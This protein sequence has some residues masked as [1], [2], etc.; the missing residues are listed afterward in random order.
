MAATP[1]VIQGLRSSPADADPQAIAWQADANG[2]R[3]LMVLAL[4][5]KADGSFGYAQMS[6][7]GAMS[8][9]L[10]A[11]PELWVTAPGGQALANGDVQ[12]FAPVAMNGADRI[13]G[14]FRSSRAGVLYARWGRE[15]SLASPVNDEGYTV[16]VDEEVTVRLECYGGFGQLRFNNTSGSSATVHGQVFARFGLV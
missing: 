16:G 6:N 12:L 10:P 11:S 1:L 9:A 8:I 7:A 3:A 13:V 15:A 4:M 14:H 5:Q 2:N